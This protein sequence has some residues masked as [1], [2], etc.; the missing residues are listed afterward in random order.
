MIENALQKHLQAQEDLKPYLATYAGVMAIFNQ[1]APADTDKLWGEGSQYGRI[2][3]AVDMKDDP[4]REIGMTLA[5]DIM[6]KDGERNQI[7]EEIEPIVRPLI[8]GYFFSTKDITLSAKWVN[9]NYFTEPQNKVC[10][11]TLTFELLAF[12]LQTTT[13]PD[14]IELINQWTSKEL[15]EISEKQITVI[16]QD[17]LPEAWQPTDDKPAIYWRLGIVQKCNWIPDTYNCSWQTAT[18]Y[19]HIMAP[20]KNVADLL[21]RLID[22]TLTIKK[23]LIFDDNSPLMIDRTIHINPAADP[24]RAGQISIEATYGILNIPRENKTKIKNIGF[25]ERRI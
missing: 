11:V 2:V 12:P 22:N 10:G 4:E 21:A 19:G 16:G 24:M 5:V 15:S 9:S 7:P 23:R 13:D 14:P 17:I 20:S 18:L 3:C 1:K 6:C 8:D 25:A